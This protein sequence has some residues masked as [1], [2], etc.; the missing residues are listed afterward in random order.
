MEVVVEEQGL[1]AS[2][3]RRG[4]GAH[5]TWVSAVVLDNGVFWACFTAGKTAS[6]LSVLDG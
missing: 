3:C 5:S 2:N 6:A 4:I 1:Y